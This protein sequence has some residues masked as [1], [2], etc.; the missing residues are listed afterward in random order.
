MDT[1]IIES[2]RD[3]LSTLF[4]QLKELQQV[5]GVAEP[6]T[7]IISTSNKDAIDMWDRVAFD[8]VSNDHDTSTTNPENITAGPLP[9]E[10][11]I[12][13]LPSNGNTSNIYR[14]LEIRHRI[15]VAED[16]LNHIR[17]LIADKSFQYSHVIRASP[18]KGV[19]TRSRAAV[20]KL[21]NQ[22]AEHCRSYT[23]CRSSF[24]ILEAEDSIL[25]KFKVLNPSDVVG[26]TAV[27]DP[28]HP[29]STRI[30]LS[31]IWQTSSRNIL[32]FAGQ[33]S[34]VGSENTA[35]DLPT[36]LECM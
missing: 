13:A 26:S 31:W 36:L 32:C 21:N 17:N 10:D 19:T 12:I 5:A 1:L 8:T 22:I 4:L 11:R 18:R 14:A 24:L 29:G 25:F 7:P 6:N 33:L 28:N 35:D 34:D 9:I 20:R 2:E 15:S 23:R 16:Q 3:E 27:L 30:K